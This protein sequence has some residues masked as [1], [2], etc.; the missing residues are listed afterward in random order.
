MTVTVFSDTV[1]LDPR[2]NVPGARPP[3]FGATLR[4][5]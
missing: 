5:A 3:G 1:S 4:G 2:P